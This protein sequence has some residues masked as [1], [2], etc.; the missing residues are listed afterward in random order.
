MLVSGTE[1]TSTKE[2]EPM[3]EQLAD[4]PPGLFREGNI[5]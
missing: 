1:A 3:S 5:S 2:P 4:K